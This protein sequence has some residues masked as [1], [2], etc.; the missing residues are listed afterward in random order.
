MITNLTDDTTSFWICD[1]EGSFSELSDDGNNSVGTAPR[2][3]RNLSG[4]VNWEISKWRWQMNLVL[5][6]IWAS[7][8]RRLGFFKARTQSSALKLQLIL[9]SHEI[10]NIIL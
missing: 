4:V 8:T 9:I 7:S 10:F 2:F 6:Y 3:R 1:A 5:Q